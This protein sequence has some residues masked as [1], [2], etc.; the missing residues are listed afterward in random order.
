MSVTNNA[1]DHSKCIGCGA[2]ASICPVGAITLVNGKA[3]LNKE[4]CKK[5]GACQNFCPVEAIDLSK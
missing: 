2:C 4:K 3:V 1:V 5:C